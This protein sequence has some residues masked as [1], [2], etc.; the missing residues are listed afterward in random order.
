MSKF[1]RVYSIV[2]KSEFT[3]KYVGKHC[4]EEYREIVNKEGEKIT[5]GLGLKGIVKE[6][7]TNN[8]T[9]DLVAVF[10]TNKEFKSCELK[11]VKDIQ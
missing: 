3:N 11:W 1:K 9:N 7:R 2:R 10:D 8:F 6:I 4:I 5:Q